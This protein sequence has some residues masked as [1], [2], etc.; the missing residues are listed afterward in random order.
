MYLIKLKQCSII[1]IEYRSGSASEAEDLYRAR[2]V[3][4]RSQTMKTPVGVS[5]GKRLPLFKA[6]PSPE[7]RKRKIA[8]TAIPGEE[9]REWKV[10]VR[11]IAGAQQRPHA[12]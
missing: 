6:I 7:S 4:F 10:E 5:M 11:M 3:L 1:K 8:I 2:V 12:A 9:I